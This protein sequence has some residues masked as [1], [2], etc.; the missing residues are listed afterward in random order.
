[1]AGAREQL[2]IR[3]PYFHQMI[4]REKSVKDLHQWLNII[5]I[6]LQQAMLE[7]YIE[8]AI[9]VSDSEA[10]DRKEDIESEKSTLSNSFRKR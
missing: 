4:D 10:C 7:Q 3:I 8:Q 1:M 6:C 2:R 5:I 9:P